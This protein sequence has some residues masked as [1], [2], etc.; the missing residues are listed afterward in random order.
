MHTQTLISDALAASGYELIEAEYVAGRQLWRIFIDRP[1]SRRGVDLIGLEDC[2]AA[3]GLVEDALIAADVPY[4]HLEVSSPGVDRALT[5][6]EHFLRFAGE[7]VKLTLQP[8]VNGERKLT[9]DLVGFE[10]D[11]VVVSVDGVVNKVPY[12]NVA[13]ARVLPQY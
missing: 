6:P 4:E 8:P 3:S 2:A 5:R 7:S 10:Q 13:R 12:A 9:G 11:H 1:D